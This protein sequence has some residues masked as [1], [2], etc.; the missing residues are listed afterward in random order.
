MED[1]RPERGSPLPGWWTWAL[2]GAAVLLGGCRTS[3]RPSLRPDP[4]PARSAWTTPAG[5]ETGSLAWPAPP[6]TAPRL[7][8]PSVS[9]GV[10]PAVSGSPA[11]AGADRTSPAYESPWFAEVDVGL[12]SRYVWRGFLVTDDPVVQGSLTVDYR[13]WSVNVWANV[14]TTDVNDT[15]WNCNEINVTLDYTRSFSLGCVDLEASAGAIGYLF[16]ITDTPTL[17]EF[18]VGVGAD[19]FLHPSLFVYREVLDQEYTYASFDLGHSF[20][21]RGWELD[22]GAGIGWGDHAWYDV[23]YGRSGA[24]VHEFHARAALHLPRGRFTLSP[25]CWYSSLLASKARDVQH[26]ADLFV[27]ALILSYTF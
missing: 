15:E 22:L 8:R 16:P 7:A 19:V 5:T 23:L 25:T 27:A 26:P 18:Y 20:L 6:A 3:L 10:T 17:L 2:L 9:L 1:D 13:N 24:A 12:Y 21:G 14:D 4:A 11:V